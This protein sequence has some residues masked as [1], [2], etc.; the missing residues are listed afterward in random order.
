MQA[1]YENTT[2]TCGATFKIVQR[3][4]TVLSRVQ[5]FFLR[6]PEKSLKYENILITLKKT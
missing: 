5:I 2:S 4:F 1:V 6:K 3:K